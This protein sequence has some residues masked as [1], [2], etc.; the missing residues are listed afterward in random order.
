MLLESE[1]SI[2]VTNFAFRI[3]GRSIDVFADFTFAG[4]LMLLLHIK[5]ELLAIILETKFLSSHFCIN[6]QSI[7]LQMPIKTQNPSS[8]LGLR[9]CVLLESEVSIKVTNF[10]FRDWGSKVLENA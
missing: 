10:E 5:L 8:F 3:V 6:T 1:V 2:K 9:C 7:K 4:Q